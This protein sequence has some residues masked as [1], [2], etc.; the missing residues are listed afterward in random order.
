MKKAGWTMHDKGLA[1]FFFGIRI[2]QSDDGISMDQTPY[3]REIVYT[4]LGKDWDTKLKSGTKHSIPLPA[5]TEF[6]ASLVTETPFD[7]NTLTAA[8]LK[9]GFRFRSILCG[10]MHLGLWTRPDLMP[11]LIRLSRFQSA[12]GEAHFKALQNIVLFVRENPERCIT[13]CR[14][15]VTLNLLHTNQEGHT[16]EVASVSAD[17]VVTGSTAAV[18]DTAIAMSSEPEGNAL[19]FPSV[20]MPSVASLVA[21]TT[22]PFHSDD[23][24]TTKSSSPVIGVGPPL[25]DGFIDAGFGSIYETVGFTGALILMFGTAVWWLCKKQATLAYSTTESEL[26]AATEIS[27]FIK[28]LRVLMADVGLPYRTAIVIG[29]DNEAARQIGHAGKVTR[30]VRHVVIQTAALQNDIASMKLALRHVGSS[31]NHSDH[32]T[33][34]LPIVPFWTH[35]NAMM[36]ARYLTKRHLTHLGF[37]HESRNRHLA[38]L[39]GIDLT[40]YKTTLKLRGMKDNESKESDESLESKKTDE[41]LSSVYPSTR[42]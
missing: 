17:F 10:F 42:G 26:Y 40:S 31:N 5:G 20:N 7:L 15:K 41:G 3:A 14:S 16:N 36:G 2:C 21:A 13:Y 28:W 23:V 8:E 6:E 11:S 4:V 9:Y 27:K 12:P 32:F 22:T 24:D 25:T 1:S 39:F 38:Y 33:K 29:E 18:I 19:T 30:N 35:T 37:A 34:L